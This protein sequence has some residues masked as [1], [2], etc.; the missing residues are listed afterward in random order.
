MFSDFLDVRRC[1]FT[2]GCRV[3]VPVTV[4]GERGSRARQI[5]WMVMTIPAH[6]RLDRHSKE[7]G[8]L[9]RIRASLHQPRR[10]LVSHHMRRNINAQ[11]R[12]CGHC[13][14]CLLDRRHRLTKPFNGELLPAAFPAPQMAV[15]FWRKG[16]WRFSL[17][18]LSLAL[19]PAIEHAASDINP[20]AA[21]SRL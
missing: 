20:S 16:D 15:Q 1:L 2:F 13:T 12:I 5:V 14:K 6:Q 7:A 3:S 8:S 9:P 19:R 11:S 4:P 17:F 18:G 21:D 10:R